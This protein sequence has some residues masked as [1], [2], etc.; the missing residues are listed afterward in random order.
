M[1]EVTA[2]YGFIRRKNTIRNP[3]HNTRKIDQL[4]QK[5]L[6]LLEEFGDDRRFLLC[7]QCLA[8]PGVNS[9][10]EVLGAVLSGSRSLRPVS[11]A[12]QLYQCGVLDC[13]LRDNAAQPWNI[14]AL[15]FIDL[16][17]E[18]MDFLIGLNYGTKQS[19]GK[20]HVQLAA[21]SDGER[22]E[23]VTAICRDAVRRNCVMFLID[24]CQ[25][26]GLEQGSFK[27]VLAYTLVGKQ[28][29]NKHVVAEL[30]SQSL[31]SGDASPILVSPFSCNDGFESVDIDSTVNGPKGIVH[32]GQIFTEGP[33]GIPSNKHLAVSYSID[34]N[35]CAFK[36]L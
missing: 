3:W 27:L 8:T 24:P 10:R 15:D 11:H 32:N 31:S 35:D 18:L 12:C 22:V 2:K 4:L 36:L 1:D 6:D 17:P 5:N 9:G 26:F 7:N 21:F 33:K 30:S 14:V 25:A 19:A 23:D 20:L 13:F 29:P 28:G 34:G 16:C